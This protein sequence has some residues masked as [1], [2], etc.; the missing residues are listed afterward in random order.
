[1]LSRKQMWRKTKCA[2]GG[3]TS[4]ESEATEDS[5][6]S[7]DEGSLGSPSP[8]MSPKAAPMKKLRSALNLHNAIDEATKP[9]DTRTMRFSSTVHICL[10]L[11]RTELKPLMSDFFWK[12]DDY[13]K[14][15]SE[16]VNELRAHLTANGIT[17]KEAIFELYQPHHLERMQWLA[18]FEEYERQKEETDAESMSTRS[19]LN[20]SDED[21]CD[22]DEVYNSD[23]DDEPRHGS[24]V[25]G[26]KL[27]SSLKTDIELNAIAASLN[28]NNSTKM[29]IKTP[30]GAAN[31][32]QWAVSWKPKKLTQ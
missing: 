15:K 24:D 12:P 31:Y 27:F 9:K 14:F 26:L 23:D 28:K 13:V 4:D 18:E 7:T 5:Y 22:L 16:A 8:T 3:S 11:S 19:P 2:S 30:S 10:V 6:Q 25:A 20:I 21:I 1:M 32:H 17:A 29:P